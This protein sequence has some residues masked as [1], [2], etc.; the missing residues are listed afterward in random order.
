MADRFVCFYPHTVLGYR[1]LEEK[2]C[3]MEAKGYRVEQ[4]LLGCVFYFAP[5]HGKTASYFI[6]KRALKEY[7]AELSDAQNFLARYH[8]ANPVTGK[9]TDF[10]LQRITKEVDLTE[11]RKLRSRYLRH[12][13]TQEVLV[14][15]VIAAFLLAGLLMR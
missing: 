9:L 1:K 4:V 14:A 12:Y 11:F 10:E 5:N 7:P 15:A 8:D 2:L 3:A 6:T 13:I